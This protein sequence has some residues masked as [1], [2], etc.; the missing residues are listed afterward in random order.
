MKKI[1]LAAITMVLLLLLSG[2][3][4]LQPPPED[5]SGLLP[6][7]AD[8]SPTP[9]VSASP[10]VAPQPSSTA[11]DVHFP[12][13]QWIL[14][15][16]EADCQ[17]DLPKFIDDTDSL[18]NIN[19]QVREK[20]YFQA[21][22]FIESPEYARNGFSYHI[23]TCMLE[24]GNYL[25]VLILGQQIPIYGTDGEWIAFCYDGTDQKPLSVEEA[26]V[27]GGTGEEEVSVAAAAAF[28]EK[29]PDMKLEHIQSSVLHGVWMDGEA[30]TYFIELV[31]YPP[32][33]TEWRHMISWQPQSETLREIDY[34]IDLVGMP[35]DVP[36]Y[37]LT[38]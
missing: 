36:L 15:N 6:A 5:P 24:A 12:T 29:H 34:Y 13:V 33:A 11:P 28:I 1:R 16:D 23:K 7:P 31:Y 19:D 18:K 27:M 26:L 17:V 30:I 3:S 32:E 38:D 20:F 21:K 14:Q 22:T 9:S 2:C 35:E 4:T 10:T 25:N 37:D 8:T